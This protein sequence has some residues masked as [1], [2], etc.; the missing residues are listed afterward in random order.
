M[1]QKLKSN[2]EKRL[3]IC[4]R[5]LWFLCNALHNISTIMHI[6]SEHVQAVDETNLYSRQAENAVT[7][8]IKG[9]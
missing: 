2:E 1:L 5:K 4:A 9:K 8:S 7:I 3:K 6:K